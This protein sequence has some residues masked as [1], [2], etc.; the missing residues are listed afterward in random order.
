MNKVRNSILLTLAILLSIIIPFDGQAQDNNSLL[1]KVEGNGI[2][3]SYLLGT[4]HILPKADF[5]IKEKVKKAFKEA[6]QIVL[7]LDMD[8]PSMQ[9]DM[10]KNMMLENG[11]NLKDYVTDEEYK[12]ID[13]AL[14]N[15]SGQGMATFGMMK[16]MTISS[17]LTVNMMGK[18]T[19]S[20]ELSFIKMAAEQKK[21]ILGLETIAEQFAV[22]DQVPY[23]EQLDDVVEMITNKAETSELLGGMVNAYKNEDLAALLKLINTQMED[24][25]EIEALL[26]N[27]NKNWIPKIGKISAEKSTFYGVG[28]GHLPGKN[29]VI[30]LLKKAGY[31]VTPVK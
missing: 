6:D 25:A 24:P 16:P 23:E 8:D 9:A 29:G 4:L 18:E 20:F 27:R 21:E 26:D 17:L 3:P 12:I 28:A 10:I 1:W 15:A 11:K 14:I 19:A 13:K 7:E 30:N 22:F 31:K 5:E 2:Q